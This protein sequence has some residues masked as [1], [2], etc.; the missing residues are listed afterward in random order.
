MA[1]HS[2]K[3]LRALFG[4]NA[5]VNLVYLVTFLILGGLLDVVEFGAFRVAQA[6]LSVA[7]SMAMLGLNT[8][9]THQFPLFTPGQQASALALT[10][11]AI[12]LT[13]VIAGLVVY[14]LTP[15]VPGMVN[16]VQE[17]LYFLS[18]PVAVAGA[19]LCNVYLSVYQAQGDMHGY[20]RLQAQ[21]K[22]LV[23]V[24]ALAGGVLLQAQTVLIAMALAYGGV[25]ALQ[26]M[27]GPMLPAVP[28][29]GKAMRGE[30]LSPLFKSGVWPFASICV[31][32][33]Y[34]NVEFL[35]VDS[36]DLTSGVAGAYSLASL[37]FIGGAAFFA[38]LQ[39]YAGS[40]VVNKKI[41]LAGLLKLQ[42]ACLAAVC[43]VALMALGAARGL[44]HAFPLK[45]NAL[46][47]DF[48][49]LVC[50]KLGLWGSYAVIGSVLNYLE[51]G[52]QGFL[53]TLICLAGLVLTAWLSGGVSSL[54]EVVV[55]QIAS[56][57]ILL[58]GSLYLV[59]HA[60]RDRTA[61]GAGG[62]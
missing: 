34:S 39:T 51:K 12:L 10:K 9:V 15:S 31:S 23:F 55:L 61:Q 42:L 53:L 38:P 11:R 14:A 2:R 32:V 52:F 4:S 20:A 21:W 22:T 59:V 46:F 43:V 3:P 44:V 50:L 13:S 26:R 1:A 37:I 49:V 7:V 5:W 57:V 45:F 41:E 58:V 16:P 36:G 27:R 33:V 30:V 40:L 29:P 62:S 6:Y 25:Y 8:A 60:Y 48:A 54:R 35:Y 56:S 47:F 17:S 18:F 19:S 28:E 24:F